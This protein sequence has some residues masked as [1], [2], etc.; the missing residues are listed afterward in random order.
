MK[1]LLITKKS[2]SV[3]PLLE[4]IEKQTRRTLV[5]WTQECGERVLSIFE[6]SYP[7][8]FRPRLALEAADSWSRGNMKMPE[9]KKAAHATHNAATMAEHTPAA[10]AAAR[11]IGHIIG[12]IHVKTHAIN[13]VLYAVT[14]FVYADP[15]EESARIISKELDYFYERLLYWQQNTNSLNRP[16]A[17]FLVRDA[18]LDK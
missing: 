16:W 3:Q 1:K 14:A 17:S 13:V 18:V 4:L 10:C 2:E 11:T 9:A 12:T 5:I 7:L 15:S 6:R 8:D